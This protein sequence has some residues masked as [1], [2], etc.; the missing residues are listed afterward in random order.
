[1]KKVSDTPQV[2][3]Y[4]GEVKCCANIKNTTKKCENGG[5]WEYDGKIY[6]GVHSRNKKN[7]KKLPK[8]KNLKLEKIRAHDETVKLTTE[9]N[10]KNNKKGVVIVSKMPMIKSPELFDG[11]LAVFPNYKHQNR[12]DGFGCASLSPKSLG[13]IPYFCDKLPTSFNLENFHQFSKIYK[14]DIIADN[15]DG[16]I[17][18]ESIRKG[19]LD[20]EPHR[21]KYSVKETPLFSVFYDRDGKEHRFTYLE[22]RYFY[23]KWYEKLA[24]QTKDFKY[25]KEQL[26]KGVNLQIIGYDGYSVDA[27]SENL[28]CVKDAASVPLG[29]VYDCYIDTT[30]PFGHELV[31]FTL[32]TCKKEYPW[33]IFAKSHSSKYCNFF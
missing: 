22:C 31:L 28:Y 25:L 33:D 23:C 17:D 3:V 10:F 13:P 12:K 7:R 8:N 5:Y 29:T 4:Y 15:G 30:K 32:L 26:D 21:H 6:C 14:Q 2:S 1:M 16:K 19:F 27:S 20:K 11:F 18:I 9:L 24:P